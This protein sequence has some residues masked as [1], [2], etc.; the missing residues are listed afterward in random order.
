MKDATTAI[1]RNYAALTPW[2]EVQELRQQAELAKAETARTWRPGGAPLVACQNKAVTWALWRHVR[3]ERSPIY[4]NLGHLEGAVAL[5]GFFRVDLL[6]ARH[7]PAPEQPVEE[8]VD[9]RH[10]KNLVD[11]MLAL[12][13]MGDLAGEVLLAERKPAEVARERRVPV[14]SVYRAVRDAKRSLGRSERLRRFAE[15]YFG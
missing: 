3:L 7:V 13:P 6:A 11:R 10:L 2:L 1:V 9:R 15:E 4:A 12:L 14:L 8:H 5:D